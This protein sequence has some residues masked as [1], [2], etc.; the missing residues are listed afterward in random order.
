MKLPDFPIASGRLLV[1]ETQHK[2]RGVF[3]TEEIGVGEV[4]EICPIIL[5]NKEEMEKLE[6]TILYDY[7]FLWDENGERAAIALG[8][9]SLYNH[10]YEPN[11][12]YEMHFEE[13]V[14]IIYAL[15]TIAPGEEIVFN[16]NGSPDD[17][18]RVWFLDR[19]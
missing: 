17:P 9:G 13:N 7:Y 16:Y 11:A 6:G 10:S 4:I 18:E 8:L 15:K 14:L 1:G 19:D 2:G 12:T 3:T 5:L